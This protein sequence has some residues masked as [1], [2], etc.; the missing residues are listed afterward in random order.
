MKE[1]LIG[2]IKTYLLLVCIF[3]IQKPLFMGYNA[4][5]YEGV[6]V[7][8]WLRVVWHG[9]K[10]DLAMAGY[11][12]ALPALLY[13]VSVWTLAGWVRTVWRVYFGLVAALLSL[14]FVVDIVL[15]GYWGFRLDATPLFYFFSSPA[16]TLASVSTGFVLLG[17]GVMV[18]LAIG[19]YQLF[20]VL[21]F[22]HRRFRALRLPYNRLTVSAVLLVLTAALF[23]PIRGGFTVST[24]NTGKVYFSNNIRLNHAA[25][26]PAF[27]LMESLSKNK[28]FTRQYRFMDAAEASE[29]LALMLDPAVRTFLSGQATIDEGHGVDADSHVLADEG[30]LHNRATWAPL[31]ADEALS[32]RC[33]ALLAAD[34]SAP[35][36]T[37]PMDHSAAVD[38]AGCLLRVQRPDI[39]LVILEGFS[40][41][42]MT[43]LGGY[44]DVAVQ[45]D[46]LCAEG[47]LFTHFYANSFRT[48]RGLVAVLSGYPAQPT[49]SIMKY[50]RKTA[51]LPSIAGSL[52][53]A[54][55]GAH[56]YYGG[57]AD[58]TNMRSYLM[59]SGFEDIVADVDFPVSDR[60]SKWGVHDHLVFRRLLDDLRTEAAEMADTVVQTQR[61]HPM[62]RVVQTSSSHEPFDV[63]YSRLDD[64][65]L[66]AFA[67][68]DSC[69][70]DFIRQYRQLPQW[71]HT[72]II[73]VPDHLGCLPLTNLE[74]ERYQVPLLLTGGAIA[75]PRR[76]DTYGSQ[77][78]I[79]ATLLAQLGLPHGQFTFSK[80]LM[81][82]HAPHFAFFTVPDAF[83]LVTP[84][85]QLIYDNQSSTIA[86]DEGVAKGQNLRPG[87]AYL[88]K[89]YD[90][91]GAR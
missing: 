70:G 25:T 64:P 4:S 57:D 38:S 42:L 20:R 54:G 85:N 89:L 65:R 32:A 22:S 60:L 41:K 49:T 33:G 69:V 2:L 80:D 52:R 48:D 5:L 78:D 11:L 59:S 79:A 30:A 8:D 6:A 44:P 76:I 34:A 90:D 82:P 1:R 88:Q 91:L 53:Q 7:A 31:V 36:A 75:G 66:N 83:G 17:L 84:D 24:M 86:A 72:L 61:S 3:A 28:D 14:I 23:I 77:H 15:Y 58:F 26:N 13:L 10:L 37:D 21:L 71:K 47:I 40:S 68:T 27:N 81:N 56:Y 45:M 87:M 74:L 12:T 51:H 73:F 67:Y 35:L 46:S 55:Y 39:C 43:E 16:D 29:R 62:F 18:V 9:L 50:P 63:P 19:L